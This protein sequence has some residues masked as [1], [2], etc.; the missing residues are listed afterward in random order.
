LT[1]S[2]ALYYYPPKKHEARFCAV[3]CEDER[4]VHFLICLYGKNREG[5]SKMKKDIT[6]CF[7]TNMEI[8]NSLEK[9][10]ADERQSLS[11]V[12][13][14]MLYKY[15]KERK[16]LS[17]V[18][19]D[20]RQFE[21]KQVALPAFIAEARADARGYQTGTIMDISL[22]GIKISV[23]K[24]TALEIKAGETEAEFDII[25][26]LPFATR[27]LKMRCQPQRVFESEEDIQIGTAFVDADFRS[28][29]TLQ[30]Y[31]M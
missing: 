24:G 14:N 22:G 26:T 18:E 10:S 16:V 8:R 28:Y 19:S 9:I 6:I 25:F 1:C 30:N 13:E 15:L 11:S 21:R 2:F 3:R 12:I 23:P 4:V 29:Q 7:R 20:Q 31:L 27:P 5:F 17:G